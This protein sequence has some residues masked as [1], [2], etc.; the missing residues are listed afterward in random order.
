VRSKDVPQDPGATYEGHQ[1]LTYAV[2]ED[3]RY[4]GVASIGWEA[5]IDAT[6][7]AK[8]AADHRIALAWEEVKKGQKSTL[9]YY[10]TLFQMD[11]TL[12]AGETGFWSF[13][14]RRHLR[15]DIFAG[16]SHEKLKRYAEAMNISVDQLRSLPAEPEQL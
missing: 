6:K 10:M 11:L 5:E 12:M 16:L 14:V 4:T 1:R 13:Q 7:V 8:A 2:A 9:H 3:G 15:P